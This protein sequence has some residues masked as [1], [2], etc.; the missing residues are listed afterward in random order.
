M[1]NKK[2]LMKLIRVGHAITQVGNRLGQEVKQGY[3][4]QVSDFK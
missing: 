4:Q 2:K 1:T 3:T